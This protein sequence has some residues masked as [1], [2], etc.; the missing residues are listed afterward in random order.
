M[1][2]AILLLLPSLALAE[3]FH[4]RVNWGGAVD[5]FAYTTG[6]ACAS[7]STINVVLGP[8]APSCACF[9]GGSNH[10]DLVVPVAGAQ[11]AAGVVPTEISSDLNLK[12]GRVPMSSG[13]GTV[14]LD[15]GPLE[16]GGTLRGTVTFAYEEES[17]DAR[18]IKTTAGGTFSAK[19]CEERPGA[20]AELLRLSSQ[21]APLAAKVAGHKLAIKTVLARVKGQELRSL[22]FFG[23]TVGCEALDKSDHASVQIDLDGGSAAR[24]PTRIRYN[25]PIAGPYQADSS[26]SVQVFG[27]VTLDKVDLSTKQVIGRVFGRGQPKRPDDN[28]ISGRF[29]ARVCR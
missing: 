27:S 1:R 25:T 5:E 2:I 13:W 7:V 19:I 6:W 20:L 22:M 9:V 23:A 26:R 10:I 24:Q 3:D 15:G 28:T 17:D 8:G 29:T 16:L 4:Y 12:I 14:K 11:L 18:P 21:T